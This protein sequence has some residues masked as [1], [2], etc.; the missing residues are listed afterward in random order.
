MAQNTSGYQTSQNIERYVP[1]SNRSSMKALTKACRRYVI[2]RTSPQL[3]GRAEN[4]GQ[5]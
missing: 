1:R 2:P 3:Q 5:M 4:S